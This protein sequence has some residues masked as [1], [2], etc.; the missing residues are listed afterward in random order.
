MPGQSVGIAKS[1]LYG[2]TQVRQETGI[3]FSYSELDRLLGNC[4]SCVNFAIMSSN[5]DSAMCRFLFAILQQKNLKDVSVLQYWQVAAEAV[6]IL[7]REQID[8][9]EVAHNPILTQQISNGHAARMRYS[10]FKQSLLGHQPQKRNRNP[11][12]SKVTKSKKDTKAK[13]EQDENADARQQDPK[14]NIQQ[15]NNDASIKT[16]AQRLPNTQLTP[17]DLPPVSMAD[18]HMQFQTRLL[19][20]CSDTDMFGTAHRFAASPLSDL[21]HDQPFDYAGA[22]GQCAGQGSSTWHQSPYSASP[23]LHTYD[24]EGYSAP[25][26]FCGEH[27]H[28]PHSDNFGIDPSAMMAPDA[29]PVPVKHE[30]WDTRFHS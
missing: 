20:P 25:A 18:A 26:A 13:K 7:T 29:S 16:E 4:G 9:N 19:T 30:E 27:Q 11:T 12:K 3:S 5:N 14:T 22:A 24:L 10:R 17:A 6:L 15:I 23:Y 21:H 1:L 8:W 2:G 28:S